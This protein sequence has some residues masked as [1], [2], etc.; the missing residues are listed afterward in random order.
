MTLNSTIAT[1]IMMAVFAIAACSKQTPGLDTYDISYS[2]RI[3]FDKD[4]RLSFSDV[5]SDNRC[6]MDAVCI[7]DGEAVIA[8][9][10]I[11]NADTI[12]FTLHFGVAASGPSDT[13]IFEEY[14]VQLLEVLPLQLVGVEVEKEDYECRV[15]VEKVP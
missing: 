1:G 10:G 8:F 15:L 5:I 6:P 14:R 2:D 4:K 7:T 12:P 13:L 3:N 9:Q 11:C